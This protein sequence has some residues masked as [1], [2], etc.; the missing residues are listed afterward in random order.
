LQDSSYAGGS[1]TPSPRKPASPY[2]EG[3]KLGG[4]I[5]AAME[6]DT[7]ESEKQGPVTSDMG[8][9]VER[10]ERYSLTNSLYLGR[11]KI[12]EGDS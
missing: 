9:V 7:F 5:I 10:R 3:W 6:H 2:D 1:G 11:W 12:F 8:P 4:L